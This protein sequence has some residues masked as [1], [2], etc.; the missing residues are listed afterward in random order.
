MNLDKMTAGSLSSSIVLLL[1]GGSKQKN[2]KQMTVFS[3]IQPA[4]SIEEN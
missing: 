4:Q 3:S 2:M 1:G